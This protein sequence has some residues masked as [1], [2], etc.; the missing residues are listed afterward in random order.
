MSK[1]PRRR[2]TKALLKEWGYK[3][4]IEFGNEWATWSDAAEKGFIAKWHETAQ[5]RIIGVMIR[6]ELLERN[7]PPRQR[8][9][10]LKLNADKLNELLNTKQRFTKW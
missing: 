8:Q 1:K 7:I 10:Y 3:W 6:H 9:L 2:V 4:L 5:D